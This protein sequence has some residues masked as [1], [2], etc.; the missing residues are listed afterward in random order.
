MVLCFARLQSRPFTS[1]RASLCR[2]FITGRGGPGFSSLDIFSFPAVVYLPTLPSS[3]RTTNSQR[4]PL[5]CTCLPLWFLVPT[6][7]LS[8]YLRRPKHLHQH[9]RIKNTAGGSQTRYQ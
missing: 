2:T 5:P 7:F 6:T 4:H 9:Q 3:I 8:D 1:R